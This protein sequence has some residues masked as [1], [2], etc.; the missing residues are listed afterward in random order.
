MIR[1]ANIAPPVVH[2]AVVHTGK[3]KPGI[4]ADPEARKEYRRA[5]MRKRRAVSRLTALPTTPTQ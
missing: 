4:Y 1:I 3:R 2:K 5:W